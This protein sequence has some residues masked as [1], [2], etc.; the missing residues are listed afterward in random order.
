MTKAAAAVALIVS[1]AIRNTSVAATCCDHAAT[2][3]CMTP[4]MNIAPSQTN[5]CEQAD[6]VAKCILDNGCCC[7]TM[8]QQSLSQFSSLGCQNN[9]PSTC[10]TAPVS[11]SGHDITYGDGTHDFSTSGST[12]HGDHTHGDHTSGPSTGGG[13]VA[14]QPG[15]TSGGE[16]CEAECQNCDACDT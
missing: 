4:A 3:E 14:P 11:C 1:L 13:G 10:D 12:V 16:L 7:E 5:M 9:C 8:L 2:Q 15:D 6:A